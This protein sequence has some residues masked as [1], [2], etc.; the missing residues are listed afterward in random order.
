[1]NDL[2]GFVGMLGTYEDRKVDSYEEGGV[3]VSTCSV[4]DSE[5]PYET[6]I[7]H[8]AYNAGELII[9]E[10]YDTKAEAQEGHDRWVQIMTKKDLPDELI[11]ISTAGL[12]VFLDDIAPEDWRRFPKETT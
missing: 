4:T 9:V 1:M 6:A 3:F 10:L 7:G 11:D 8:P 2:F 12:A 5:K